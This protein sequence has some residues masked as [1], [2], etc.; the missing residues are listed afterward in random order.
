M[1]GDVPGRCG[2]IRCARSPH[3]I[4][5]RHGDGTARS[6]GIVLDVF[7]AGSVTSASDLRQVGKLIIGRHS[8][9]IRV[10]YSPERVGCA[11]PVECLIGQA[12]DEWLIF[13][14]R[15]DGSL[16]YD[17][18]KFAVQLFCCRRICFVSKFWCV[19]SSK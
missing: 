5:R 9:G 19:V 15:S 18:S 12:L 2:P 11:E 4:N 17:L 14:V 10:D 7:S 6:R 13:R 8:R 16:L 3:H 1:D